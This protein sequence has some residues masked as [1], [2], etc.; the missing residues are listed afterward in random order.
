MKRTFVDYLVD[1]ESS[2]VIKSSFFDIDKTY[3]HF[4]I[5]VLSSVLEMGTLF[6]SNSI[7]RSSDLATAG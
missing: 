6:L 4:H 3:D 7:H 2:V 1:S 5:S